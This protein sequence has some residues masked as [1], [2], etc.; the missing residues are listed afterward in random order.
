MYNN[1]IELNVAINEFF[2]VI[3]SVTFDILKICLKLLDIDLS[4][5]QLDI[6]LNQLT[7][8]K[9]SLPI[10]KQMMSNFLFKNNNNI[11]ITLI[12]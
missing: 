6:L 10:T 3:D 12:I 7:E 4:T 5:T 11:Q 1:E 9:P 2:S 8:Y